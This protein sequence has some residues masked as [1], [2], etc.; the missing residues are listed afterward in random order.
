MLSISRYQLWIYNKHIRSVSLWAQFFFPPSISST[1]I[2]IDSDGAE[3][4]TNLQCFTHSKY[5]L[6]VAWME[7]V[8]QSNK[9]NVCSNEFKPISLDALFINNKFEWAEF[10]FC[11]RFYLRLNRCDYFGQLQYLCFRAIRRNPFASLAW[12]IC[13]GQYWW[14][15][16]VAFN[17]EANFLSNYTSESAAPVYVFS[18]C[19]P[20]RSNSRPFSSLWPAPPFEYLKHSRGNKTNS[21]EKNKWKKNLNILTK[22]MNAN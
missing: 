1:A 11:V 3:K 4:Q 20:N 19:F 21:Y 22:E 9:K 17:F 8:C 6:D 13:G 15:T 14:L 16:R 12:V 5:S 18:Q 10:L 7:Y 2:G